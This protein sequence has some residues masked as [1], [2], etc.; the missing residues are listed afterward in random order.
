MNQMAARA[1]ASYSDAQAHYTSPRRRDPVKVMMEEVVTHR[2]LRH[3]LAQSDPRPGEPIRVLD[4]GCGTGDGL[5]LLT[6]SHE[7]LAPVVAENELDYFGIDVDPDMIDTAR[8]QHTDRPAVFEV[9]DMRTGLPDGDFDV[10]MS[11]GVP[12]SHLPHDEVVEVLRTI[13]EKIVRTRD[14]AVIVV[15]VLGRY[16]LEWTPHW[17][18]TRWPYNMSFFED[19]TETIHDQMSFF[20]RRSLDAAL[21]SAAANAGARLTD[22]TFTDRSIVV[23]RH[24]ATLTFNEAIPPYRS[25]LNDLA[26]GRTDVNPGDLVL[27]NPAGRAPAQVQGFFALLTDRWNT[28]VTQSTR[29]TSG[30]TSPQHARLLA[31]SLL[32]CEQELQ[33]GLGVGHS[34]VATA[35]VGPSTVH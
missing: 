26:R 9:A 33:Q 29:A 10:Y 27:R 3:A 14:N 2:V 20:D 18:Q 4:V 15:D 7:G 8:S 35:V 28:I 17:P 31:E 30:L 16:S 21:I 11:C 23:G 13:M 22:L 24:T 12:Y 1:S 32:V 19:A 6:E 25:L 34:L 5:A